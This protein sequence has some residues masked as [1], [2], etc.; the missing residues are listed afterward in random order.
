VRL[1]HTLAYLFCAAALLSGC[2]NPN[3]RAS[4][5][6]RMQRL[7]RAVTEG[8]ARAGDRLVRSNNGGPGGIEVTRVHDEYEQLKK[9]LSGQ[10]LTAP[11]PSDAATPQSLQ[12]GTLPADTRGLY[13]IE[14][15][16]LGR[17]N[18]PRLAAYRQVTPSRVELDTTVSFHFDTLEYRRYPNHTAVSLPLKPL[19]MIGAFNLGLARVPPRTVPRQVTLR[20]TFLRGGAEWTMELLAVVPDTLTWVTDERSL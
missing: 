3:S 12:T 17:G 1:K 18:L 2:K 13:L 5:E 11:I 6:R 14:Y 16:N 15:F 8:D 7:I 9:Q 10:A 20:W 19:G 4:M